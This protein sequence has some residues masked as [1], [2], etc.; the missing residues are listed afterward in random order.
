MEL[1]MNLYVYSCNGKFNNNEQILLYN[2]NDFWIT[3]LTHKRHQN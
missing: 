2:T 3:F 1:Y